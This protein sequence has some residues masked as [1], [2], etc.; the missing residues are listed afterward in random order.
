[1]SNLS[2]GTTYI[3]EN[4]EGGG[5][6]IK[7]APSRLDAPVPF[8]F[9]R[10]LL[11]GTQDGVSFSVFAP[12]HTYADTP[13]S[14]H[15]TGQQTQAAFP[16]DETAKYFFVLVAL[17]EPRLRDASSSVIPPVPEILQRLRGLESCRD[18]TRAAVNFH[19]DY[20]AR[21]KLRVRRPGDTDLQGK[22][23]WQ[24]TSLVSLAL[25]FDVVRE[26]HLALLPSRLSRLVTEPLMS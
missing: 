9:A 14:G 15:P 16:M 26:E 17:C 21:M 8:E 7:V 19:I 1:M 5:E 10:V 25:R 2:R 3:V 11:P 12:Q 22:A 4:P 20:L 24:R 13:T 23:D 18:L 6:F